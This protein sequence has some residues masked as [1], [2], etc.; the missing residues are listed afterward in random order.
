MT[1]LKRQN[2]E[3]KAG[4]IFW[5][6]LFLIG[7]LLAWQMIPAKIADMQLKDHMEEL[8]KLHPRQ[9]GKFFREQIL[10]RAKDLDIPLKQ[11]NVQVEKD[12][13]RVRMRIEYTITLDFVFTT[14]DWT[15]RH[16]IE[17]DIFII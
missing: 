3:G 17:R 15:F 5:G 6:L 7:G 10:G 12:T 16:D 13:S 9:D 4:C 8:A 2:G 11:E 14:F 1:S